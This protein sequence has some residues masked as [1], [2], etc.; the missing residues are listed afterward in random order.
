MRIAVLV[1]HVPDTEEPRHLDPVTAEIDR[2]DDGVLDEICSRAL[3][4]A[5]ETRDAAGGEV[6]AVTKGPADAFEAL[7]AALA[8]GANEA[9]HVVDDE[10]A[11]ADATQTATVLAATLQREGFDLV[12]AGA[13][14]TDGEVGALP[15]MLAERLGVPHL[16]YVSQAQVNG[17]T[18][19]A[20]R[21]DTEISYE[22][23]AELPAVVS[24]TEKIAEPKVPGFRG[25]MTAKRKKKRTYSIA[26]LGIDPSTLGPAKT[27]WQVTAVAA[28]PARAKGQIV[29]DDG[30][31]AQQIIDF[32][33]KNQIIGR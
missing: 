16:S 17:S 19:T 13:A 21:D 4:W 33:T 28:K 25:I 22:L 11:T 24:A 5:L 10:L 8:I 29:T 26:D 18:I 20:R 6:I 2:S 23:A 27:S 14:S 7:R 1:K 9:V 30:T 32:L 31:G 15:A 12:V 3:T